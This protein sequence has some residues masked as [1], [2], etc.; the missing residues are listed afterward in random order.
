MH[1]SSF[2][3]ERPRWKVIPHCLMA[4]GGHMPL[5][6]TQFPPPTVSFPCLHEDG[7]FF[8]GT[9]RDFIQSASAASTA[10]FVG[11]N[12]RPVVR[13]LV[14]DDDGY[15]GAGDPV[16]KELAARALDAARAAGAV[17]ADVR[18]TL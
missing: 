16:F 13:P 15:P 4:V 5:I 8:M 10:M 12:M 7:V 9:R 6:P 17:Y 11:G 3:R 2:Q 1:C 18:F 14:I